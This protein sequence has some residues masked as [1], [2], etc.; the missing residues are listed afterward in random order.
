MSL[1]GRQS[2]AVCSSSLK[3]ANPITR[4]CLS[5]GCCHKTPHTGGREDIHTTV[6]GAQTN[7]RCQHWSRSDQGRLLTAASSR[8][9]VRSR[10]SKLSPDSC[11]NTI[12]IPEGS[13]LAASSNAHYLTRAPPPTTIALRGMWLQHML[14]RAQTSCP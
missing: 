12:P 3:S 4:V 6:V 7:A 9:G 5:S 13:P 14:V 8:G 11:E 10:G 1:K 2:S